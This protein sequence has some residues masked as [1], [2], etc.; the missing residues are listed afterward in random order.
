MHPI[1]LEF[2]RTPIEDDI[3]PLTKPIVG[4]SGR[5]YTNLH[6][7][8][9]TAVNISTIGYNSYAFFTKSPAP[10]QSPHTIVF[11]AEMRTCGARTLVSSDR[12]V[13]SR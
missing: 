1:G 5:V 13:G 7:P 9:G 8:K 2:V 12:N 11:T 6:I 4:N 10:R 3:V